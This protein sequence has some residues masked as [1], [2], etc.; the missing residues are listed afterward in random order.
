[1]PLII[2]S[3]AL[4]FA[5]LCFVGKQALWKFIT[6]ILGES[7]KPMPADWNTSTTILGFLFTAGAILAFISGH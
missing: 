4:F 5:T 1:M 2:F 7:G 3:I 6:N